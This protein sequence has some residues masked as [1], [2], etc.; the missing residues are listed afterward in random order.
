MAEPNSTTLVGDPVPS[1]KP[2]YKRPDNGRS[3]ALF[4]ATYDGNAI[5]IIN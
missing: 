5:S 1:K 2:P 3:V 4:M